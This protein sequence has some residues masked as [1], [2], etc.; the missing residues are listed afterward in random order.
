MIKNLLHIDNIKIMFHSIVKIVYFLKHAKHQFDIL[1]RH[2]INQYEKI[3]SF[4]IFI[5]F[6]WNI[7]I[8]LLK[9]LMR[10]K[11]ALK[12][13]A[14]NSNAKFVSLNNF[15]FI[16]QRF[17]LNDIF[18]SKFWNDVKNLFIVLKFIHNQQ[19]FF[20]INR[21]I[22]DQMY[23]KW[24]KIRYYLTKMLVHNRYRNTIQKIL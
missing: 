13:Y 10:N 14:K 3:Y 16:F 12:T 8:I 24:T 5:I 18:D 23:V 2:Q 7:Q 21:I 6:C 17:I 11:I 20:E 22:I 4:I 1:R 19:K 15:Q 9:F